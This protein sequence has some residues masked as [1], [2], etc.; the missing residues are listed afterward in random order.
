MWDLMY[1]HLQDGFDR[2]RKDYAPEDGMTRISMSVDAMYRAIILRRSQLGSNL[3]SLDV[4]ALSPVGDRK[5]WRV[6][7]Y[8][9][10]NQTVAQVPGLGRYSWRRSAMS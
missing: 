1:V 6:C 2:G 4:P 3:E 7:S 10:R 8:C 5:V 9:P